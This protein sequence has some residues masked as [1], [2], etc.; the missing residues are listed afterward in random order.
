MISFFDTSVLIPAFL[1]DHVHHEASHKALAQIG[2]FNSAVC[3]ERSLALFYSAVTRLPRPHRLE[4]DQAL[5]CLDQIGQ[6]V[7][8]IALQAQEYLNEVKRAVGARIPGNQIDDVLMLACA[9]KAS[10]GKIFT[11]NVA[12][13]SALAPDLASRMGTP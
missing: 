7:Q 8:I 9:R 4:P 10:A 5:L 11:W 12:R 6:K 2:Q 13:L 1:E 3:C